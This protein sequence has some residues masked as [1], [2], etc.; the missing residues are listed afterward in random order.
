MHFGILG[1]AA[2]LAA[3]LAGISMLFDLDA[4]KVSTYLGDA[5]LALLVA[6]V[7]VEFRRR[8]K[9]FSKK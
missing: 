4:G 3:L 6:A 9:R 1:S 7:V 5:S 2:A 8:S